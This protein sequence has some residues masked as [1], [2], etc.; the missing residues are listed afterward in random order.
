[1]AGYLKNTLCVSPFATSLKI[2]SL[3]S[4]FHSMT[5]L[6]DYTSQI[7]IY[8]FEK[9][10]KSKP[11]YSLVELDCRSCKDLADEVE[12]NYHGAFRKNYFL[13]AD[14]EDDDLEKL[15]TNYNGEDYIFL[16]DT[17][18]STAVLM[19]RLSNY[20]KKNLIFIGGDGWGTWGD[21]EV[22]RTSLKYPMKAFHITPWSLEIETKRTTHFKKNYSKFY[23]KKPENKLSFIIYE[24]TNSLV[25]SFLLIPS[26]CNQK[27]NTQEQIKCSYNSKLIHKPA[28]RKPD[29]Y[30]VFKI[31]NNINQLFA[32]INKDVSYGSIF[33]KEN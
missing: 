18:H 23:G 6:D 3:P 10:F 15:L 8:F 27:L 17:A 26:N 28:W 5:Y 1:M 2:K 22:G 20:L 24:T 16:P 19:I 21:S 25:E 29:G 9:E 11:I 13:K 33:K 32:V 7:F 12:R 30:A 31:E 4:N 14:I